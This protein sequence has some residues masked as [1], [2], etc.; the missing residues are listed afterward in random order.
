MSAIAE[1]M[2]ALLPRNR[3]ARHV[4]VLAGGTALSQVIVV[5]A[6]PAL[7]RIYIPADFG[8]L[9]VYSSVLSIIGVVSTLR[10]EEAIPLPEDDREA[11]S[12]LILG[13][14]LLISITAV[15]AAGLAMWGDRL[16]VLVKTPALGRYLWV[17]PVGVCLSGLYNLVNYWAIRK[18]AF[19]DIARTKLTQSA[20]SVSVQLAGVVVGAVALLLGQVASQG[21]GTGSLVKR[22]IMP[23]LGLFKA[24]RWRDLMRSADRWRRFPLYSTWSG[25]LNATGTQLPLLLFAALFSSSAAGIYL[26]AERVLRMP[27]NMLGQAIGN[28]FFSHAAKARHQSELAPLVASIHAKLAAIGMPAALLVLLSGPEVFSFVFGQEWRE[29]GVFAQWMAPWI[30]LVFI[31]SP[32]SNLFS[33]MELQAQGMFFQ[34]LLFS[35]RVATI[36]FGALTGSL[37]TTVAF[38]AIGS[39][40]C[41]VAFLVWIMRVSGNPLTELLLST[42]RSGGVSV[43]LMSPLLAYYVF[44][45]QA[46]SGWVVVFV[47]SCVLIGLRYFNLLRRI[48]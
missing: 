14:G 34:A 31:T 17:I 16:A 12:V 13:A 15:S 21:V 19:S 26:L 44:A 11:A 42:A 5:V 38:F 28:V 39:A 47:A 40:A 23:Q 37:I 18:R 3:F 9:A 22:T 36:Y 32:L 8:L 10:Y 6:S 30:Y 24:V 45:V 20:A 2:A 41:W 25:L 27:M 29:A 4:S 35:V 43:L 46:A 7:T 48:W 1:R 33:V